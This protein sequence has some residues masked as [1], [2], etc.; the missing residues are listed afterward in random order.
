M[1]R[2]AGRRTIFHSHEQRNT[3]LKLLGQCSDEFKVEINAYCLMS[4]HFDLL[5]RTP[6]PTL[7]E[8]MKYLES[9]YVRKHNRALKTNGPLF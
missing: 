2:G 6:H 8:A 9:S 3:F 5:V 7:S 4:N 1:N